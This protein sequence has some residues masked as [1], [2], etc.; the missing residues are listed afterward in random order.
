MKKL[1]KFENHVLQRGGTAGGTIARASQEK[2]G[3]EKEGYVQIRTSKEMFSVRKYDY[4]PSQD[5]ALLK[6]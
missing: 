1:Q 4:P 2:R 6:K 5:L 3:R